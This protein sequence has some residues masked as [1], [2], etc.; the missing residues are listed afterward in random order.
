MRFSSGNNSGFTLIELIAVII[1][2][3][4]LAGAAS[5]QFSGDMEKARVESTRS[6]LQALADAIVGNPEVHSDGVRSDFGYVG[7]VGALPPNLT[8][9]SVNPGLAT[10]NGPY[11]TGDFS[12][13]EYLKDAWDVDYIYSDT[14][15][16]SVGSGDN[17]DK[18]FTARTSNLFNNT[19]TGYILDA[20]MNMPGDIYNDSLYIILAYPD[21]S[22]GKAIVSANP[23]RKGVFSFSSVPVGN[24]ILSVIYRP[25]SDTM[26]YDICVLPA[27]PVDIEIMFPHDL[28]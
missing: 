27:G 22:G 2:L 19:V 26:I 28:W 25:D 4:I 18:I 5:M 11:I 7:D 17:I 24:H 13:D 12:G 6:E 1:I 14:L 10:W 8:A 9:L 20:D 3:G 16:R 15:L 21:G 23:D